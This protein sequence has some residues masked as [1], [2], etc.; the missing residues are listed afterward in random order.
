MIQIPKP[1]K[2]CRLVG[3]SLAPGN[4]PAL[5]GWFERLEKAP[6]SDL[7]PAPCPA[8]PRGAAAQAATEKPKQGNLL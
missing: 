8:S 4:P 6:K 1:P 2:G 5:V 7:K 3:Y